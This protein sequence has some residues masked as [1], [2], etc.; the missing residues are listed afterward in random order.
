MDYI[1]FATDVFLILLGAFA[2]KKYHNTN[3]QDTLVAGV[4]SIIA[5]LYSI[6]SILRY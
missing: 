5:G 4:L 2:I 6:Y 1:Y 3:Q